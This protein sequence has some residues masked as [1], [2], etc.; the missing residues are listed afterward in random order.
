VAALDF[1]HRV[2]VELHHLDGLSVAEVAD[3]IGL[4]V[5]TV[6]SRLFHARERLRSRLE[7]QRTRS[8]T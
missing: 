7:D 3:A 4:P 8:E 1:D 6:K 2:V 5:G